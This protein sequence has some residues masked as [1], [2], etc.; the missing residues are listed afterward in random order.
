M[1]IDLNHTKNRFPEPFFILANPRSG[2][3]LLRL[4]LNNH[5]L[6][7]VPPE[8]G[9]LIWLKKLYEN[10]DLSNPEVLNSFATDLFNSRKFKTWGVTYES[11][12]AKLHL[13][14]YHNYAELALS[15]YDLYAEVNQ[16][17]SILFG[18]KNNYYTRHIS[19]ILEIFPKSKFLHLIRDGRDVAASFLEL[20]NKNIVSQ[21]APPSG[22]DIKSI[23][24]EWVEN[25]VEI[26]RRENSSF[27]TVLY[28]ELVQSPEKT[29]RTICDFLNV[30]YSNQ[31]E[32]FFLYNDE[33]Q[34]FLQW[35]EKTM[36][37]V[38]ATQVSRYVK[39]LGA[40]DILTFEQVG[41][42]ILRKYGYEIHRG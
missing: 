2:S 29:L 3:S 35:K 34:E 36:G 5:E 18:D 15:I 37:A 21:Y 13:K 32:Q 39:D 19:E 33:P 27:L 25:N 24:L 22:R 10:S 20:K 40:S 28:E 9:F 42:N 26:S 31:M 7:T 23:A 1:S 30:P 38:T 8:C 41:E 4:M 11:I 12:L 6:I 16:K 17:G 14:K